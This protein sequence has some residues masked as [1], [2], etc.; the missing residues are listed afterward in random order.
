MQSMQTVQMQGHFMKDSSIRWRSYVYRKGVHVYPMVLLHVFLKKNFFFIR[1]FWPY[2]WRTS[3]VSWWERP[4]RCVC[5]SCMH[6][7]T[8]PVIK[9]VQT[10][11]SQPGTLQKLIIQSNTRMPSF[12]KWN[13]PVHS[14]M[15]LVRVSH[16][17]VRRLFESRHPPFLFCRECRDALNAMN[18]TDRGERKMF[19]SEDIRH[20]EWIVF[21]TE[22]FIRQLLG[23]FFFFVL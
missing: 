20:P 14:L 11:V 18:F 3:P 8:R 2:V 13:I 7:I 19:A 5:K 12:V 10:V 15:L 23:F 4:K 17:W 1:A 22:P 6:F 16:L 9:F 21:K